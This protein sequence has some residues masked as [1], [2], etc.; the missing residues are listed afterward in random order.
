ME[1]FVT[2]AQSG[3]TFAW[4][5]LYN[6][7]YPWLYATALR[8]CGNTPAAKDAVQDAFM[9]AYL[10]LS[11]LK[12]QQA[13]SGWLKTILLR[14][15]HHYMQPKK[16]FGTVCFGSEELWEDELNRKL[17]AY[18]RHTRLHQAFNN[19]SE[20]LQSVL[21]MRYFSNYQS[22]EEMAQLLCIPVGTVRSRLNQAKQK[23]AGHWQQS[24][25]D[26][27]TAYKQAQEWNHVYHNYFGNIHTSLAWRE[28]LINHFRKDMQI[29][30]TSGKTAV[31]RNTIAREISDD[32]SY[33]TSFGDV[34]VTSCSAISIVETKNI[35]S[36]EY[37]DRCPDSSVLVLYRN[38]DKV[39][40]LHL[41][42]SH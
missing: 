31:G 32:I 38:H 29:I 37:P 36:Q 21:L 10:K 16:I 18:A 22:Y 41:H 23:I 34:Q 40:R 17:D 7:H 30:F 24:N 3:D 25:E 13:F 28:K 39:T 5:I 42:N 15:C 1:Q 19:L 35:N 14:I 33:G 11:Q 9:Q 20:T 6:H 4:N 12:D 2:A 27:D 26:N 8:V